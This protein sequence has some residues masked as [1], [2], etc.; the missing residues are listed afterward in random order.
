M[1]GGRRAGRAC[2][3]QGA[4]VCER[5]PQDA[6]RIRRAPGRLL[7]RY[8]MANVVPDRRMVGE[9]LVVYQDVQLEP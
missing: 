4:G 9:F 8:G 6:M 7:R 2:G 1:Q 5:V 3:L